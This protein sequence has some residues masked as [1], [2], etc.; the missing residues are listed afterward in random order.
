MAYV[1]MTCVVIAHI[2][3]A[4]VVMAYVD[5]ACVVMAYVVMAYVFC[6]RPA[7]TKAFEGYMVTGLQSCGPVQSWPI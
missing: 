5:M 6:P 1:V 2:V 4:H 3:M 7:P